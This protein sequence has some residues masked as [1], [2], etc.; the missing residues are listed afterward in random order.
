[1]GEPPTNGSAW[2]LV[3]E[4]RHVAHTCNL[5]GGTEVEKVMETQKSTFPIFESFSFPNFCRETP[6]EQLQYLVPKFLLL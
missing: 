6:K 4:R 3:V 2:A 5:V 1:M